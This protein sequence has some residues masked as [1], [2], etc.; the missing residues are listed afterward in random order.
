MYYVG[1][2]VSKA[3]LDVC[4]LDS[5]SQLSEAQFSNDVAGFEQINSWLDSR[6]TDKELHVCM[7]ATGIYSRA[8]ATYCYEAGYTT[9]V[10]NPARIKAYSSSQLQRNKTDRVDARLIADF[11]RT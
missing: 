10:V 8:I 11:C 5:E 2:D 4:L 7:E 1:I 6:T 9:S 3:T